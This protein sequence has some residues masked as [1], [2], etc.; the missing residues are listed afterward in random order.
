MKLGAPGFIGARLRQARESR[1]LSALALSDLIGKSTT[2]IYQYENGEHAP[3]P[4]VAQKLADILRL[5]EAFFRKPLLREEPGTVFYR[6]MAAATMG[7]RTRA[8]RRYEWLQEIVSYLREYVQFPQVNI[9]S[10]E[11]PDEAV[12]FS[13]EEIDDYAQ[14]CRRFWNL[15]D[16]PIGNV[17]QL[18]ENNGVIVTRE[19]LG[20]EKLDAFSEYCLDDQTPY[21]FLGA[22]KNVA[23][24]SR[25]DA[26][27]ELGHLILHRKI[28]KAAI[29][30]SIEHQLLEEQADRFA[31]AFLLPAQI[32]ANELYSA[33]LDAFKIIKS[34][35]GLSI[36]MQLVRAGQ[37]NFIPDEQVKRL[38]MAY[39][40]RR[41]RKFE[42]FDD[43]LKVEEPCLLRLSFE[44][45]INE[46]LQTRNGI[47][48]ALPLSAHDIESLA[49]LQDG[50]FTQ[51][52]PVASPLIRVLPTRASHQS[53]PVG[54]TGQILNFPQGPRRSKG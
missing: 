14:Q 48:S 44:L 46:K 50:F 54:T 47:L 23:C 37:L 18:L 27:H 2:A 25:F 22:D 41:W 40:R 39:S 20:A 16:G 43:T 53:Q 21:V 28:K 38:W 3:R 5:P 36:G 6:S 1:G 12:R 51:Q 49:G 4:D 13:P 30:R 8:E 10:F 33:T 35:W 52:E 32:F 42:P 26:A 29:H 31:G 17:V 34:K 24:R 9:P 15:G 11:V 45:I 19:E 7:A